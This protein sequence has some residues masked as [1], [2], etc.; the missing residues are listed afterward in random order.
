MKSSTKL[1]ILALSVVV[2]IGLGIAG[3]LVYAG[4]F[5]SETTTSSD[6]ESKKQEKTG[7]E[8]GLTYVIVDTGQDKCYENSSEIPFPQPG[9]PFYGQDAQYTGAQPSYKDNSD[10]TVTDLNTGLMWQKIPDLSDKKTFNEAV[11][12]AN[13]LS[14]ANY[15]D[16]R[17]PSIKELYSLI[18]FNGSGFSQKPY[19]DTNYFD[20]RFGD[21]SKGERLIDA[22][23]WSSTEYVGTT[24]NGEATV[25]GVNFADGRIKGYPRDLGRRGETNT[26]FVRYVRGNPNYGKNLFVDNGDGTI[27]DTATGLMW[28][29][30]DDGMT[31][32]WQ[33]ALSY[34]ENLEL[35]G[36]DDWRLPNAKELQSIIDYSRSPDATDPSKQGPAIDPSFGIT[37]NESW[38]W[39]GTTHLDAARPEAAVYI[40]FGQAF[41]YM[42]DP[43]GNKQYMNVHG[44]GAQRSD[45]KIGDP[46]DY[47]FGRGPQGDEIRIYNYVRCVRGGTK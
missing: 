2:V 41:G 38:F 27:T 1:M 24:M 46:G 14:L 18:N 6:K 44:A 35:A 36:H 13:M 22:Q 28:Q 31:R 25:F 32:N 19:I 10:G 33:E 9:Q 30:V 43:R 8:D 12:G 39:T 37:D 29:K 17:L 16:W 7:K 23:Y 5:V 40:A 11:T 45:P 20:F 21:E 47:P 15:N 42:E 3:W 4:L 34:A 26:Q